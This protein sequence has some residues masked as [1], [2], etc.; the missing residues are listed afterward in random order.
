MRDLYDWQEFKDIFQFLLKETKKIK[1]FLI[2]HINQVKTFLARV[3]FLWNITK[4]VGYFA[5]VS[6]TSGCVEVVK[7]CIYLTISQEWLPVRWIKTAV[8]IVFFLD[9]FLS[10]SIGSI[11]AETITRFTNVVF[12]I[13]AIWILAFLFSRYTYGI[14]AWKLIKE[15]SAKQEPNAKY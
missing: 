4:A 9:W 7:A 13:W 3:M 14:T 6:I 8:I 1:N 2:K 11:I 15:P 10:Y 12:P 5:A